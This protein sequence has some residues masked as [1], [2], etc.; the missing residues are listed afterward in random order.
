MGRGSHRGLEDSKWDW[1][2]MF[3]ARS[4]DL[5]TPQKNGGRIQSEPSRGTGLSAA[6]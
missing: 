3:E 6:G 1:L 5:A 4:P 2:T